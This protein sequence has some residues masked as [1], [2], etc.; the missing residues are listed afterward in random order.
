MSAKVK[1]LRDFCPALLDVGHEAGETQSSI[2][3]FSEKSTPKPARS[4]TDF[5]VMY[6]CYID[7]CPKSLQG[8]P[9]IMSDRVDSNGCDNDS[10]NLKIMF[11]SGN[12]FSTPDPKP[13]LSPIA[14]PPYYFPPSTP[15]PD[16]NQ[17]FWRPLL[18]LAV[19]V[20]ALLFLFILVRALS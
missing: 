12:C 6:G 20:G 17:T 18:I 9:L 3:A 10:F 1:T 5:D 2:C 4:T 15:H 14:T 11:D 16:S 8:W 19:T 13:T 7:N